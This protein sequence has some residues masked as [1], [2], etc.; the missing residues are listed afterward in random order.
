MNKIKAAVLMATY[1]GEKYLRKQIDSILR[2]TFDNFILVIRDDG[3][4]DE[5]IA[6]IEEYCENDNRIVFL[7]NNSNEK[8]AYLN[9]WN[10]LYFA[11]N[12]TICDYYFL[13]DQDDIWELN[14]LERMI[15][16]AVTENPIT[17][18][19]VYSDMSVIN[20]K[21]E[22][23]YDSYDMMLNNGDCHPCSTFYTRDL[24]WG[25]TMMINK[26]LLWNIPLFPLNDERITIMSHDTYLAEFAA[27]YGE[28]KYLKQTLTRHRKHL[29]NVSGN[30]TLLY[31]NR[32]ILKKI[33]GS[34][35]DKK[36]KIHARTYAQSI[37]ALTEFEK[38][39]YSSPQSERIKKSIEKGG[40][41]GVRQ[42]L[43]YRVKKRQFTR[44]AILYLIMCSGL[45]RRY[46]KTYLAKEEIVQ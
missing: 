15:K 28:V 26:S 25:C 12:N 7:T 29:D 32:L 38:A 3:S 34:S 33:F 16:F 6:I 44:S 41:Y 35:F 37:L 31:N 14:K 13:C 1:N 21:D 10:L 20:E 36:S 9:F 40:I 22:V 4:S 5:T 27:L 18:L 2:Q 19:L 17:P 46:L 24:F 43:L 8:G 30:A 42:L 23:I 11:R 45:Y 39:G